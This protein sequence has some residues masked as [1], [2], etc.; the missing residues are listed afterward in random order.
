M[1]EVKGASVEKFLAAPGA[2]TRADLVYGPDQGLVQ[3]RADRLARTICDDPK[4]AFRVAE[5]TPAG[6]AEDPEIL[7]AEV[8]QLSMFGGRRLVRLRELGD[9]AA[10][11]TAILQKFLKAAPPGDG[12]V[13]VQAGDIRKSSALVKAFAG[14]K[15][16]VA[17]PCYLDSARDLEALIGQT[18]RAHKITIAA[19]AEEYLKENLGGDRGITRQELE[20]LALYAGD[21]GTVTLGDAAA[22]VGDTSAMEMDDVLFAAT[23]GDHAALERALDRL[24]AE[25]ENPV[26]VL[27]AAQRHVS[28]FFAIAA[29]REAGG[30]ADGMAPQPAFYKT[31]D[32]LNAQIPDWPRRRAQAAL[33]LLF[34]AEML[35][36]RTGPPPEAVCRDALM[37]IARRVSEARKR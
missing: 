7:A 22:S 13:L 19:D 5:L 32:R 21:G 36:K 6:L 15:D 28:R 12:F 27:R 16:A 4:D 10:S 9:Y 26:T 11:I 3:E 8:G 29:R 23:G 2:A 35:T 20:K 24:Y 25:G 14:T 33:A 37:R 1:S 34:E 31:A 17:L 18:M 30:D